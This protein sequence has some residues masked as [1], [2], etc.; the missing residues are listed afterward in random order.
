MILKLQINI[1]CC[2]ICLFISGNLLAQQNTN[3][4][5]ESALPELFD[6]L[7]KPQPKSETVEPDANLGSQQ[8][9]FAIIAQKMQR[10]QNA[11]TQGDSSEK[12]QKI[13]ADIMLDL[14][15]LL[16]QAKKQQCSGG[17]C[18]KPGSGNKPGNSAG[19]SNKPGQGKGTSGEAKDSTPEKELA[20]QL[21][22]IWGHLPPK[23]RESM[24]N[25]SMDSFLPKY[26]TLIEEYYKKLA[27]QPTKNVP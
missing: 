5:E 4:P 7:T 1:T 2:L 27:E 17:N 14:D 6:D 15:K 19:N 3:Q 21:K 16:D 18:N 26:Q 22:E 24:Q 20:S 11:L 10:S 23:V 8:D 13:Q 25:V 12:T 9:P